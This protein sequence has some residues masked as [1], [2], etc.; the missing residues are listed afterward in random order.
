MSRV[1]FNN[2]D[3]FCKTNFHIITKLAN[4]EQKFSLLYE[5]L[6]LR[7]I[8]RAMQKIDTGGII[9]LLTM[10]NKIFKKV[11]G[12][13]QQLIF[14]WNKNWMKLNNN[15]FCI[16]GAS[17]DNMFSIVILFFEAYV[18]LSEIAVLRFSFN[19]WFHRTFLLWKLM[20]TIFHRRHNRKLEQNK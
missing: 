3:L 1:T 16:K 8:H 7:L 18:L 15:M 13:F 17:A 6:R 11:L 9:F 5:V 2:Y 19:I 20:T 14:I 12:Y 10:E 4:N